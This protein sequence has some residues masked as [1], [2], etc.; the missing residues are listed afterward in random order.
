MA[1]I[2]PGEG[3]WL[4]NQNRE[5][6]VLPTDAQPVPDTE[7]FMLPLSPGWNLIGGPYVIPIRF[8]QVRVLDPEGLEWSITEASQRGLILP[9]PLCLRR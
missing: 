6:I 9:V 5:T 4:L 1:N 8:D 2:E 7:T 3:L